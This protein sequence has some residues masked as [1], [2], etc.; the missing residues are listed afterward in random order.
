MYRSSSTSRVSD[1]FLVNLLP[2]GKGS[3]SIK[4]SPS[5]KSSD[6]DDL[7]VVELMSDAAKKEIPR[8]QNSSGENAIHLIPLVLI[9]CALI[10]WL[11]SK[12]TENQLKL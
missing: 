5:P 4:S 9:L 10:L 7:P 1:E 6:T 12:P 3:P 11:F 8:P 2:P